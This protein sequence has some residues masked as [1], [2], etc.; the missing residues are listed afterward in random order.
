MPIGGYLQ[1]AGSNK[2][3]IMGGTSRVGFPMR[4]AQSLSLTKAGL[5]QMTPRNGTQR[6]ITL[7]ANL[8]A[9]ID[10]H[11]AFAQIEE[12]IKSWLSGSDSGKAELNKAWRSIDLNGNGYVSLAEIDRWTIDT[13][14]QLHN[15]AALMRA[16]KASDCDTNSYITKRE[17]P[18]LL[19]NAVY[20]NKLWIVF[21]MVDKSHDHRVTFVEFKQCLDMIGMSHVG[22]PLAL[23][24]SIDRNRGGFILFDE[25]VKFVAEVH[26]PVDGSSSGPANAVPPQMHPAQLQAGDKTSPRMK[27]PGMNF[28]EIEGKFQEMVKDKR[29]LQQFWR[30]IDYNG[31]GLVSLAEI[32]KAVVERYPVLNNKQ[33]LMRAYKATMRAGDGY[34]HK[35][36]FQKLLRNLIYFN[37]VYSMF[38]VVDENHDRKLDLNEFRAGAAKL[39]L[40]ISPSEAFDEF[41]YMD[42]N[43]GGKI[44]F[45][46]FC[47][48]VS[49]KKMPID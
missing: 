40:Q 27:H 23:F 29:N 6:Q 18:T 30:K 38:Q 41:N 10:T 13:F 49:A 35:S 39:G 19:R 31:N 42:A 20:F 11:G 17:F 46:E 45:D 21:K 5:Q 32:D 3:A 33:A 1:G 15:K 47:K 12:Q 2:G 22:N 36:E 24:D 14:P 34:V 25:F 8:H 48:W 16:Y 28:D 43:G 37:K 7:P 44:L 4:E 9:H 26:C